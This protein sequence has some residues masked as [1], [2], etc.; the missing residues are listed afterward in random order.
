MSQASISLV[1][2][3]NRA[4]DL[5]GAQR[6]AWPLTVLAEG[7]G[8]P[9]EIFIYKSVPS[10]SPIP[11]DHFECIT[12]VTD[13]YEVPAIQGIVLTRV[14]Q[15]P[16]YRRAQLEIICRSETEMCQVWAEIQSQVTTL[17]ANY[18]ASANL[19]SIESVTIGQTV[20]TKPFMTP[21]TMLQLN[22]A[23]AGT[24]TLTNL[25]TGALV[26]AGGS[27][28]VTA[29]T[30]TITGG[31][32]TG[33]TAI[34]V[35]AFGIVVSVNVTAGGTG[36]VSVPTITISGG[37]GTGATANAVIASVQGITTPNSLLPGWLPVSSAVGITVPG[38]A[39][40][41]YN[42]AA[43]PALAAVWPPTPPLS[44][45]QL[46]RNGVLLPYGVTHIFT[47]DTIW[48]L[49]FNPAVLPEYVRVGG[50]N[51]G[52]APWPL[53]YVN[54]VNPGAVSPQIRISIFK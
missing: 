35:I 11:G 41:F 2:L 27:G 3:G 30:V 1:R 37:S 54:S 17:V 49:N 36:Y 7:D 43:D 6:Q 29:P 45:S 13:L 12:T 15:I 51:D 28:Y 52:N 16:F 21:P 22:Y 39:F 8:M 38:G 9:S 25:V 14:Y 23:P 44:G 31:G 19:S 34:A 32:G 26:T 24:A 46:Y 33:A 47:P 18:N 5:P 40:L 20:V 42:I 4:T 50:V 48:W 10:D 53:D